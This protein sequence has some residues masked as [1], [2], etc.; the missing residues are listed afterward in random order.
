MARSIRITKAHRSR[1]RDIVLMDERYGHMPFNDAGQTT[2]G[3]LDLSIPLAHLID[4]GVV[5]S[6][7]DE[8][9]LMDA[10]CVDEVYNHCRLAVVR[11]QQAEG[12]RSA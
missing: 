4:Q 12:R 5:T 2:R 1:A 10:E 7:V 8:H 11:W 6:I 3:V 9:L